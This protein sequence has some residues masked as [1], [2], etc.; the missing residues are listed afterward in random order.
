MQSLNLQTFGL[1]AVVVEPSPFAY[2]ESQKVGAP[3]LDGGCLF[4]RLTFRKGGDV[5]REYDLRYE[6]A[7]IARAQDS[8]DSTDPWDYTRIHFPSQLAVASSRGG[9]G[10]SY[11]PFWFPQ[12]IVVCCIDEWKAGGTITFSPKWF[13]SKDFPHNLM[14]ECLGTRKGMLLH[15]KSYLSL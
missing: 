9:R 10:V 8:E 11:A 12:P 5:L 3:T 13:D 6:K 15:S 7:S 2:Q 1:Q 14:R 4:S